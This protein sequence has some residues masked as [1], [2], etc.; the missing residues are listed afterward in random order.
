MSHVDAVNHWDVPVTEPKPSV[1]V[2][3]V[4]QMVDDGY[5]DGVAAHPEVWTVSRVPVRVF[6]FY[7]HRPDRAEVLRRYA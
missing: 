2:A 7:R 1:A 6:D 3:K 5:E 4:A